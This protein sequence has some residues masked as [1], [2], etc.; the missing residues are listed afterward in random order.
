M[1]EVFRKL[2]AYV[3]ITYDGIMRLNCAGLQL[4]QIELMGMASDDIRQSMFAVERF[5][6]LPT[7]TSQMPQ[8]VCDGKCSST[9][10]ALEPHSRCQCC[11]SPLLYLTKI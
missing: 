4:N 7:L 9:I 2:P 6:L 10:M 8:A 5:D 1:S 11:G 3:I